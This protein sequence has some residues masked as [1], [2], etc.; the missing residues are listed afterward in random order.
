M[1]RDME[2]ITAINILHKLSFLIDLVTFV[3]SKTTNHIVSAPHHSF[4]FARWIE[5]LWRNLPA[6][7]HKR[8][9]FVN[10]ELNRHLSTDRRKV[11]IILLLVYELVLQTSRS[12]TVL[13]HF[14]WDQFAKRR[15][16]LQLLLCHPTYTIL[17]LSLA[18]HFLKNI[19]TL[20]LILVNHIGVVSVRLNL[21]NIWILINNI[22]W[23]CIVLLLGWSLGVFIT[24]VLVEKVLFVELV[25]L[26][27][28]LLQD[29]F[30]PHVSRRGF[31]PWQLLIRLS[32]FNLAQWL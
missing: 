4:G 13:W 19:F 23:Y 29:H 21:F 11:P 27:V 7:N 17:I 6:I 20:I 1:P 16:L 3:S 8:R 25:L 9:V 28:D 15:S 26:D 12:P 18:V 30:V 32:G 31:V 24:L 14:R 10:I 5:S 22:V 2:K